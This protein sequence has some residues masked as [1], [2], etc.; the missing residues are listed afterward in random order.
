MAAGMCVQAVSLNSKMVG[1]CLHQWQGVA[2]VCLRYTALA[3]E[4]RMACRCRV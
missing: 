1:A 2:P 4:G 3:F